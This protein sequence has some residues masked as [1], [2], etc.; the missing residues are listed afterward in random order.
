MRGSPAEFATRAIS[1]SQLAQQFRRSEIPS[2]LASAALQSPCVLA[3]LVSTSDPNSFDYVA[4]PTSQAVG[5]AD[6]QRKNE[7]L[8]QKSFT[9]GLERV[10]FI[11]TIGSPNCKTLSTKSNA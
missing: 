10:G 5:K 1:I 3:D 4:Y 9:N 6:C 2:N 11:R 7:P 8:T